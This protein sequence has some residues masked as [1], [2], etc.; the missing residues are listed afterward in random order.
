MSNRNPGLCLPSRK[1]DNPNAQAGFSLV[2][3]LLIISM[4]SAIIIP[5][6][7]IM[8]QTAQ[9]SR[10]G[11]L[12]STRSILLNS[13]KDEINPDEPNFVSRFTDSSMNTSVSESGQTIPYRRVVDTTNSGATTSMKRTT[14]FYLY[15]NSTDAT[16]SPRYKTTLIQYAKVLRYRF[17]DYT[18]SLIDNC[19]RNWFGDYY[20]YDATNKI[21]GMTASYSTASVSDDIVNTTG[22]DDA[23]FQNYRYAPTINFSADVENGAYTVKMYFAETWNA[24]NG[25]TST[26]RFNIYLEGVKMNTY[27]PYSP[28][29]ATGALYT[30]DVKSYD[31]NVTDG[32]LNLTLSI[33]SSSNDPNAFINAIEIKKRT[34]Q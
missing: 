16:S 18:N 2:E 11:Y 28:Y 27:G 15:N 25:T 26:R 23:L 32:V 13:L 31:V 5:F 21:A 30:A 34:Q 33:D 22:N 3:V 20:L 24:I 10:G 29:E 14:D 4:L 19:G 17:G 12:Q 1:R 8:T 9:T 7:L 6:T